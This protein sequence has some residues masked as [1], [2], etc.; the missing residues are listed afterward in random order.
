M[1]YLRK[2]GIGLKLDCGIDKVGWLGCHQAIS[3]SRPVI[4]MAEPAI[5]LV[6]TLAF[7]PIVILVERLLVAHLS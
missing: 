7:A 4:P 2:I 6:Q 5:L 3:L 1:N